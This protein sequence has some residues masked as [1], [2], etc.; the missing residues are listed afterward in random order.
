MNPV[1][2][3]AKI[4]IPNEHLVLVPQV[5]LDHIKVAKKGKAG[6]AC[7][8]ID[9][10]LNVQGEQFELCIAKPAVG[11]AAEVKELKT[12]GKISFNPFFM[13]ETTS[14]KKKA[15]VEPCK[16]AARPLSNC[17]GHIANLQTW[18]SMAAQHCQIPCPGTTACQPALAIRILWIRETQS[19]LKSS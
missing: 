18:F 14:E 9:H 4:D 16:L 17:Q 11:K 15:N 2:V 6:T 7:L 8:T 3:Y 5:D 1:K 19:K 13:V 12:R 10:E